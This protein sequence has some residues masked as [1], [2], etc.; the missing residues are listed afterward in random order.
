MIKLFK[1][2]YIEVT[3]KCNLNCAFCNKNNRDKKF[4][5]IDEFKNILVK[6][7]G[8]TKYIYLHVMGEPLLH[9]NINEL[10]DIARHNFYINITT[11]GYFI[12][13]IKN[14]KNIRQINISLHSFNNDIISLDKYLDNIFD[15]VNILKKQTYISLRL[16]V[17]SKHT[18]KIIE[19]IEK[20]YN[21]T[22]KDLTNIKLENNVF[23]NFDQEFD[24]P[25]LDNKI[26]SNI[27]TCYGVRDH[28]G[29]L[30]DGTVIPCCLDSNGIIN[31]GNI[32]TSSLEQI[33]TS[34]R[35]KKIKEGFLHNNKCE[36]LCKHCNFIKT[37]E[38]LY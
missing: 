25:N 11:N 5:E 35:Y 17:N 4:I 20:K 6:I 8:Y 10:I 22:I 28:I 1:K 33:I 7:E 3:N 12:N 9:P 34:D 18:V 21:I 32:Y 13:K 15:S 27:G 29:I 23:L 38:E 16:W 24:W 37:K 14:N 26:Y 2:I 31:L 36:E 30:V 19:Y